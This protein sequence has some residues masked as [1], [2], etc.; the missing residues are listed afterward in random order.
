M[1]GIG[2]HGAQ[3]VDILKKL[4]APAAVTAPSPVPAAVPSKTEAGQGREQ[5]QPQERG[6]HLTQ[7]IIH[8]S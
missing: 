5:F 4:P 6:N 1:D 7:L 8:P 3:E 2:F